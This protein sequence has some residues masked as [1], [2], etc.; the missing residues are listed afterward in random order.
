MHV[1]CEMPQFQKTSIKLSVLRF[2]LVHYLDRFWNPKF[3][4]FKIPTFGLS[5]HVRMGVSMIYRGVLKI[6][7]YIVVPLPNSLNFWEK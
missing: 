4:S 6:M 2:R 3:S 5:L 7:T 1:N